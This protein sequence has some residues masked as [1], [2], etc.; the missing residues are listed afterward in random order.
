MRLWCDRWSSSASSCEWRSVKDSLGSLWQLV[1]LLIVFPNKEKYF[2]L[3]K[4]HAWTRH[5]IDAPG[6]VKC[7][8]L[9][10]EAQRGSTNWFPGWS[11]PQEDPL[12]IQRVT[13]AAIWVFGSSPLKLFFLRSGEKD[14]RWQA[15]GDFYSREHESQQPITA[16]IL[17]CVKDLQL[18][19]I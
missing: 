4:I 15:C 5:W 16:K 2:S 10:L 19:I 8:F 14:G 3:Q 7:S 11:L 13:E 6:G 17:I 12:S 18:L 9:G 1:S